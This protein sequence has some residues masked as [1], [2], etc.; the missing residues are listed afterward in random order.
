MNNRQIILAERPLEF[1]LKT[2]FKIVE[3]QRPSPTNGE[4]LIELNYISVDPYMRGRMDEEGSRYTPFQLNK[5]L[6]GDAIGKIIE[7]KSQLF[8]IGDYVHG[9]MNWEEYTV[10]NEKNIQK[11]N[12]DAAPASTYL[13]LLGRTGLTAYF[14]I[15][16][17][18]QPKK[19]ETFVISAAAGAVGTA[20]GQLAKNRGCR[21]IGITGTDQKVKYLTNEL[22]FDSAINYKKIHDIKSALREICHKGIDVYFDNVGG[23]ISDAV[24]AN[25]NDFARIAIC[26][27]ISLYNAKEIPL[28]PRIQWYILHHYATVKGFSVRNYSNRYEEAMSHLILWYKQ[29]KIKSCENIIEGFENVPKA[30]VG[31]FKGEN[32]GKQIVKVR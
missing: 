3:T 28:G 17:I 14:G 32:L 11:I 12:T 29:G 18:C 4:V 7:S 31:L 13:G 19:G 26:G 15:E 24:F 27:Q 9:D 8:K 20:A 2:N 5:P 21:V 16:D 10:V 30:F 23:M 22:G 1:P 6:S 25:L